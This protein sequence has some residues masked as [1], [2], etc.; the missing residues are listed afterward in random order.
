[1]PIPVSGARRRP[2]LQEP[3]G[4]YADAWAAFIDFERRRGHMREARTLYK[5]CYT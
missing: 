1:M 3:V 4:R 2:S 5:R